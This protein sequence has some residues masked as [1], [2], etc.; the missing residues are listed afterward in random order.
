MSLLAAALV[1]MG[2][3]YGEPAIGSRL[4]PGTRRQFNAD[5]GNPQESMFRFTEC[6][7]TLNEGRMRTYL[8]TRSKAEFAVAA[9]AFDQSDRAS[10][11]NTEGYVGGDAALINFGSDL[12][13][14]RGMTAEAFLRKYKGRTNLPALAP[15]H[16]Y[17]RDWF[18][19]TGR[20]VQIDEMATC[21]ADVNPAGIMAITKSDFGS[22]KEK[23]AI[24]ALAP[25]V[26]Q[27]L[28]AGYKMTINQLGLRTALTEALYHRVF[29]PAPVSGAVAQ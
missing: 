1:M 26:G 13:V 24:D 28:S 3:S 14:S 19:M 18:V 21:V 2:L 8:D 10:R 12:G 4:N 15:Q 25:M 22:K 7:V 9:R 17:K 27:C 6:T 20:A 11:C 5:M 23:K 16:V 29:D